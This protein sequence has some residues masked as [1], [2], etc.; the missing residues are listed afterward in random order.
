MAKKSNICACD[1]CLGIKL[2]NCLEEID[3][4][5]DE[6]LEA[7]DITIN[8]LLQLVNYLQQDK[9]IKQK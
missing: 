5:K 6:L 8:T 4:L 1:D 7:K 3:C 2:E 9:N